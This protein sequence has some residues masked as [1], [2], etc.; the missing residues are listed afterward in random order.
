[1]FISS[2]KFK[3]VTKKIKDGGIFYE[4]VSLGKSSFTV[5]TA[6]WIKKIIYDKDK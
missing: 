2:G 1:V 5:T 3:M 6:R 4:L